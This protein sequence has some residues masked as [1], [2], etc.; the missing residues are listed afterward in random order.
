MMNINQNN[1]Q[2]QKGMMINSNIPFNNFPQMNMNNQGFNTMPNNMMMNNNQIK[3][4]NNFRQSNLPLMNNN[5]MNAINYNMMNKMNNMNM[6]INMNKNNMMNNNINNNMMNNMMN[7]NMMVNNNMMNNNM[8]NNMM[9]NNNM[10]NNNMNKNINFNNNV[11][12]MNSNK[13]INQNN[14]FVNQSNK[15]M[16]MI[17]NNNFIQ[18]NINN[19]MNNNMMRNNNMNNNMMRNNMNNNMMNNNNMNNNMMNSNMNNNMMNSNMNNNMI[20][21]NINNN[22]MNSNI[23]NNMINSNINNNMMNSNMNNNMMNNNL[24]NNMINSNMNNKM[25]NMNNMMNK[26]M[27]GGNKNNN[28][29]NNKAQ[30]QINF[31][32]INNK[33]NPQPEQNNFNQNNIDDTLKQEVQL[34]TE[35]VKQEFPDEQL[36]QLKTEANVLQYFVQKEKICLEFVNDSFGGYEDLKNI[37]IK[38]IEDV[39]INNQNIKQITEYI[40]LKL[41]EIPIEN[42]NS[43]REFHEKIKLLFENVQLPGFLIENNLKNLRCILFYRNRKGKNTTIVGKMKN[44]EFSQ[45]SKGLIEYYEKLRNNQ[46]NA[47]DGMNNKIEL[48]YL[49]ISI[50]CE[51]FHKPYCGEKFFSFLEANNSL[52]KQYFNQNINYNEIYDNFRTINENVINEQKINFFQIIDIDIN[53]NIDKVFN[54]IASFYYLLFYK[55]K[56]LNLFNEISNIGNVYINLLLNNFVIFLDQ[57]YK[58]KIN[59]GKNLFELLQELYLVDIHYLISINFYPTL[60]KSYNYIEIDSILMRDNL[61]SQNYQH[62]KESFCKNQNDNDGFFTLLKKN[63]HNLVGADDELTEYEK[64][65]KLIPVDENVYAN[66]ITILIDGFTT[67]DKNQ[68]DQWRDLIYSFEKE[69]MFYFFKWPSDSKNNILKNGFFQAIK[70]ASIHFA[71]AKKRAKICGKMLAY[72]LM[73]SQFFKNFQINL[74]GFSLG[75]HVIKHCLKEIN[76]LNNNNHFI[77]IKNV[78]LIAAATHIQNKNVWKQIINNIVIDRFINC[79]SKKDNI[80]SWL[81]SLCL[82]KPAEGNGELEILNDNGKNLVHNYSFTENKYGHLNYNYGRVIDKVFKNYKNI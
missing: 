19:N 62:L 8:N 68:I 55:F 37:M 53:G 74:I 35:K 2:M 45:E 4:P 5:N 40:T 41:N 28:M 59:F 65:T 63:L 48:F 25:N 36:A 9:V 21:S 47:L 3:Y 80:L 66:S 38:Q 81:Y 69:T 6:N 23:N 11:N 1:N 27:I 67:E 22:M 51:V 75:N 71:S 30:F 57:Q 72:I 49:F 42:L 24:N 39:F 32:F 26:N 14:N 61:V 46:I 10:M 44:R 31:N 20:N 7:N 78:I 12:M 52:I 79:Y 56:D 50:N 76:K 18:N 15:N 34:I 29:N 70:N 60:N 43:E 33:K 17:N 54:I 73:S 64:N 58:N 82:Q 16:K 13:N 77:K